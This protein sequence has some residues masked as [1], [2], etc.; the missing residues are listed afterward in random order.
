MF[1]HQLLGI[2][3]DGEA[4]HGY[5]MVKEYIRRTGVETNTGY[6]YRDLQKLVEE[7]L[8]ETVANEKGADRRRR[9]Y[10]IT[11]AGRVYFDDWFVSIPAMNLGTDGDLAA[12]AIFFA[13]VEP[14]LV[15]DLLDRWRRDLAMFRKQIERQIEFPRTKVAAGPALSTIL[16]R[17]KR[18]AALEI[19]FLDDLRTACVPPSA[20]EDT[21]AATSLRSLPPSPPDRD[22][23]RAANASS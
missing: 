7:G 21:A 15:L 8:V 18:M 17:R 6:A 12:R 13:E 1:R 11:E 4:H 22:R 19:A 16:L 5:A 2:L 9:P 10:R 20:V 3:R 14:E 23:R